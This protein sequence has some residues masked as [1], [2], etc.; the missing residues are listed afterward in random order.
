M[1]PARSILLSNRGPWCTQ[2]LADQCSDEQGWCGASG[3]PVPGI[4]Q[5]LMASQLA[6][7]VFGFLQTWAPTAQ[8]D[9]AHVADEPDIQTLENKYIREGACCVPCTNLIMHPQLDRP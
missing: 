7:S 4:S 2:V 6:D 1:S 8:E 9:M 3:N 5:E